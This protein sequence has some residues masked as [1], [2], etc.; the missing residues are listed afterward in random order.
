M[1]DVKT[2]TAEERDNCYIRHL[3]GSNGTFSTFPETLIDELDRRT[4]NNLVSDP[5]RVGN[6]FEID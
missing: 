4:E 5:A 3:V 1:V 6:G 2:V